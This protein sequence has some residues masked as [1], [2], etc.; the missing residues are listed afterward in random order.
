M[1]L[2]IPPAHPMNQVPWGEFPL[3]DPFGKIGRCQDPLAE[4]LIAPGQF[5]STS[6]S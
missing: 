5:T 3:S 4:E 1:E 2:P 6:T